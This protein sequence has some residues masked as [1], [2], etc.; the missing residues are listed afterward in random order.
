MVDYLKNFLIKLIILPFIALLG[1]L[2]LLLFLFHPSFR[3]VNKKI[4]DIYRRKEHGREKDYEAF[5]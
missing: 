1:G 2:F 5:Y 4:D 3:F